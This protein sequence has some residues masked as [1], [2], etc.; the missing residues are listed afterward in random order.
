MIEF[1]VTFL[2]SSSG[3]AFLEGLIVNGW[4]SKLVFM[5]GHVEKSIAM[6]TFNLSEYIFVALW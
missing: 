6:W 2:L 1:L 4:L 5:C 3:E